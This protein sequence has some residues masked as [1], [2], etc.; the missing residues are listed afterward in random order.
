MH[1]PRVLQQLPL[2]HG[3]LIDWQRLVPGLLTAALVQVRLLMRLCLPAMVV[4]PQRCLPPRRVLP[5]PA[6]LGLWL[7]LAPRALWTGCSDGKTSARPV[8]AK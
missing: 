5:L 6:V 4:P 7:V 3:C 8:A 2:W 1:R